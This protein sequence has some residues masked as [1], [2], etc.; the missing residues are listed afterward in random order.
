MPYNINEIDGV[1]PSN[2]RFPVDVYPTTHELSGDAHAGELVDSQIPSFIMRKPDHQTD[3]HTMLIDGRDVSVDGA[4]LDTVETGAE[5]N[6]ISD[7]QANS[8]TSGAHSSWHHHDDWYYRKNELFLPGQS[9]INWLNLIGVPTAFN[10]T[11]HNHDDIY[12]TETEIDGFLSDYYTSTQLDAGQLDNRYYTEVEIDGIISNYYNKT[13]LDEGQLDD[14]YYTESEINTLLND[15]YSI[16]Q[17]DGGQL[18]NRYFTESEIT[19][20]YY[21]K[22]EIDSMVAGIETF[23][24]KGSVETYADLP[25][26]ETENA[27]YIVRT[28]VDPNFEGFY[29]YEAGSWIFLSRNTGNDIASHNELQNLN[30]GDYIHLTSAEYTDLTDGGSTV[31]H[32]HDSQYY[33]KVQVDGFLSQ[34]SD[35]THIHD[36]RYYTEIE[37]D[38]LLN[39]KSDVGHTHDDRYFTKTEITTNYYNKNQLNGGQL[40]SRYYN[41]TEADNLLANKSD[42]THTHNDLYYEKSYI[43]SLASLYSL[44]GH[45]HDDRYYTETE[46]DNLLEGKANTIHTHDDRYFTETEL[47]SNSGTSGA[48]RIGISLVGGLTATNVQDALEELKSQLNVS[49]S[50]LDEAYHV[51]R[52]ITADIGAVKIDS[53]SATTAPLELSNRSSAPTT[54]LVGGQMVVVNNELYVFNIDKNKWLTPS[55]TISFG[56]SGVGD[57]HVLASAGS[58]KNEDSGLKMS[59][60]GTIISIALHTTNSQQGKDIYIRLNQNIVYTATTDSDGEIIDNTIN[61]DFSVG[62][63]I[64]A[65]ID[66]TGPPIQNPTLVIEYAWRVE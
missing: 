35:I 55:K 14:R 32:A 15:Y 64:S 56:R 60:D 47:S 50:T 23:G 22:S 4:K 12:Y 33:T 20:N 49:V 48:K 25:V 62:D 17:L 19:T 45:K 24:I 51:G 39:N 52:T 7:Q 16:S 29:K 13:D 43:D 65:K 3:P 44:I 42:I 63:V 2:G 18:D 6:N 10:P 53:T 54:G 41:K 61:V 30:A 34:K 36:D 40:D 9:E 31:L 59:K 27:I 21:N 38:N 1:T 8:L 46:I 57:G 66:S 58:V 37:I 11:P 28:T 5:V 26:T